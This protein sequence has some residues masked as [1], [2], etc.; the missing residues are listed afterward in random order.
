M[1]GSNVPR[2]E[3][4][5]IRVGAFLLAGLLVV[6][7]LVVAFGRFGERFE[8]TYT[9]TVEFPNAY[10]LLKGAPV[11]FAG[12]PVGRVASAPRQI[13]EG[14]AVEVDL[15]IYSRAKIRKDAEFRIVEVGM[16]GDRAVEVTP[17]GDQ[18]PF[19]QNGDRVQGVASARVSDLAASAKPVIQNL[20]ASSQE[21]RELLLKVNEKLLT[22]DTT[23]DLKETLRHLRS[24]TARLD[25]ILAQAQRGKGSLGRLLNDPRLAED[26]SAFVY[27]LRKRGILFYTDVAGRE[28][29]KKKDSNPSLQFRKGH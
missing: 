7:C 21:I 14:R 12:A 16:L 10:G 27:N 3:L 8:P 24:A 22:D 19:L 9:I 15:R 5:E 25:T 18:A 17:K 1:V 29:E 13:N 20:E 28:A 2:Q 4:L 6:G 11:T 26:L 23:R